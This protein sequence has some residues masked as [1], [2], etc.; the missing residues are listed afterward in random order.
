MCGPERTG[1]PALLATHKP[2][3]FRV[4]PPNFDSPVK[5]AAPQRQ[6][7]GPALRRFRPP[8]PVNVEFRDGKPVLLGGESFRGAIAAA[9]GPFL[10]SGNWW[11]NERWSREEWDVETA[12]GALLRIFR[13]E[14]GCYLE[15]IYD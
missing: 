11:D 15:G 8:R 7:L 12:A 10:G 3:S 13:A 4:E 6:V 9:A 2:D 14:N 1:T 5:N